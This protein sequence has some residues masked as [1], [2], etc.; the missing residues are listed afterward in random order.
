MKLLDVHD[1]KR[2]AKAN[3]LSDDTLLQKGAYAKGVDSE[4]RTVTFILSTDAVDRDGDRIHLN[5]WDLAR[6]RK[7]P[8]VLWAHN[9]HGLPIAKSLHETLSEGALRSTAQFTTRDENPLGDTVFRLYQ[10]GYLNAVSIGGMPKRY[11]WVDAEERMFG[12]D[13]HDIELYEYSAVPIPA[14]PDALVSASKSIDLSPLKAEYERILDGEGLC[15]IPRQELELLRRAIAPTQV[16]VLE[17][18][19]PREPEPK[20][21]PPRVISRYKRRLAL[22]QLSA[23]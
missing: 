9:S 11:E 18:Q 21:D 12:M 10:G 5:A 8:I 6:Y 13:I 23:R 16:Q 19:Q 3:A 17:P 2:A 20:A 7:N 22:Y 15:I 4:R 14:H 1:W